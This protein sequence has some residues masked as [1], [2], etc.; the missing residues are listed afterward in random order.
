[1]SAN[2]P[3]M[4]GSSHSG[5]LRWQGRVVAVEDLHRSLNG[6]RELLVPARAIV[7]PL[8]AEDL[9]ARGVRITREAEPT[10]QSTPATWGIG[11]ERAQPLV[12]SAVR[13]LERDGIVLWELPGCTGSECD[14][15]KAVA[16]RVASG[17][18]QGGVLFCGDPGL[19]CC[20]ANKV[21][22]LRAVPVITVAQAAR[23]TLTLAANLLVVEM[24][25][26]TYFEVRQILRTLCESSAVCPPGVACTLQ[27]L[28]GHAHR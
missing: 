16:E 26:R 20:V 3:T 21:A 9:R 28:D 13:A 4:N 23:A 6:H 1:M 19:V 17:E 5:V 12:A 27:E 11:Q 2:G 10:K 15:A 22:G 8:A 24:P 18:C 14:W 25:G 7:T